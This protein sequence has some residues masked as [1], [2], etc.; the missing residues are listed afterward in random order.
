M[1]IPE[2]HVIVQCVPRKEIPMRWDSIWTKRT[3]S[4]ALPS[5]ALLF[6]H[7][8]CHLNL[9]WRYDSS[10]LKSHK[11]W[12]NYLKAIILPESMGFMQPQMASMSYGKD[13]I[14]VCCP[15]QKKLALG[16]GFSNLN[17]DFQCSC[18]HCGI[19]WAPRGPA[20]SLP[21]LGSFLTYPEEQKVAQ[22]SSLKATEFGG[23]RK[24]L[25]GLL[26]KMPGALD[27]TGRRARA[28]DK[29]DVNEAYKECSL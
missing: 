19:P 22:H 7:Q 10:A 14:C 25:R 23:R 17:R 2:L 4:S 29:G 18:R 13:V 28:H 8:H 3:C 24:C 26:E 9:H 6:V 16:M 20:L 1:H 15:E 11:S 27:S 21:A 12:K 5:S